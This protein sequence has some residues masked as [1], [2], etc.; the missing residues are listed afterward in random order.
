M[1]NRYE[2]Q[3]TERCQTCYTE[4]ENGTCE[5]CQRTY[6]YTWKVSKDSGTVPEVFTDFIENVLDT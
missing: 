2:K 3:E 5:T 1:P 4:L 6:L